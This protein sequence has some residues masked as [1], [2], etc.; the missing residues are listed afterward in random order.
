MTFRCIRCQSEIDTTFKACPHCG[1]P[2]T[3][4]LRRYLQEPIDGKYEILER[5]GAG[6]MGDVYKVRHTFLGAIRVVKV[7][8]GS[9]SGSTDAHDRFLRE[10]RL[11]TRVQHPSVATLHDFSALPDGAHYMV[12]EYIEGENLAQRIRSLG[13]LAPR[14]AARIA[15]QSLHGLEAIHRAGIVHRDISPENIMLTHESSGEERV[16]IIDLGV[17]KADEGESGTQTGM[18]IGKLRYASPEHLGFMP[19]GERIDGRAD[20]YSLAVVLYEMLTGRPPFEATSPHQYLL[21]HSRETAFK[22]LDLPADLPGG[23]DL[24]GVMQ[25][26]LERDRNRRFATASAFATALEEV[27]RTLAGSEDVPTLITPVGPSGTAGAPFRT[28]ERHKVGAPPTIIEKEPW[29]GERRS[30]PLAAIGLLIVILVAA[31]GAMLFV[32]LRPSPPSPA[33]HA[34]PTAAAAPPPRSASTA[35]A[36]QIEVVSPSAPT[37]STAAPEQPVA[38]ARM[39]TAEAKRPSP[40]IVQLEQPP[41]PVP[42]KELE[43]RVVGSFVEGG[44]SDANDTALLAARRDLGSTSRIAIRGTG[45]AQQTA[46]LVSLVKDEVTVSEGAPVVV[47]FNGTVER[48]GMG[49]KRRSAQATI[50]KDGRI[51]FRYEMMPEDY[52]V[53]DDPAEAFARVLI[54]ALGK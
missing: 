54:E 7:I 27:A 40:P 34:A 13:R 49:R 36:S 1:E 53:G 2:M 44:D 21:L 31:I 42:P 50:R 8:R 37:E 4:F 5:L 11:A 47:E 22:P 23:S 3:E 25:K 51:V 12:W 15:I 33:T 16:K 19:E 14:E 9:I 30:L 32:L 6:G 52:R 48:R 35:P 41:P 46:T 29:K 43:T 24:Q 45:D 20:L 39:Q 38:P 10:A 28:T 26:A 17:A 18:F